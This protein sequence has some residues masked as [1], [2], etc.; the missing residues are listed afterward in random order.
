MGKESRIDS[1]RERP[2]KSDRLFL[3]DLRAVIIDRKRNGV[4]LP[5]L[6]GDEQA[7]GR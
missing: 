7:P 2:E 5:G 4:T 6:R 1:D 3:P